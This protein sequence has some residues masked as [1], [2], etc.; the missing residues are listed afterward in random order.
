MGIHEIEWSDNRDGRDP[1][2]EPRR[3]I[4]VGRPGNWLR[5][6]IQYAFECRWYPERPTEELCAQADQ[7][8]GEVNGPGGVTPAP[9]G[10]ATGFGS[11]ATP[12]PEAV[13]SAGAWFG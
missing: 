6:M 8:W 9:P 11:A 12:G 4:A 13:G 10:G 5:F 2:S 1:C 7:R 3:V